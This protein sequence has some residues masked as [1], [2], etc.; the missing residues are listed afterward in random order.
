MITRIFSDHL[1]GAVGALA[2]CGLVL[3]GCAGTKE[4]R[5][6]TDTSDACYQYRVALDATGDF[7]A[8]DIMKGAVVGAIGGAMLG[9]V[10]G[11]DLKSAAIGAAGGALVGAAGGYWMSRQQQTKDKQVLYNSVLT[12]MDAELIKVNEAQFALDQ[13]VNC[14]KKQAR[15]IR[16][17]LKGKRI[18]R[19]QAEAQFVSLRGKLADDYTLAKK[20][21]E[22]VQKRSSDFLYANEQIN[23]GSTNRVKVQAQ[24]AAARTQAGSNGKPGGGAVQKRNLAEGQAANQVD[25]S[26][27]QLATRAQVISNRTNELQTASLSGASVDGS[28]G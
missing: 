3:A 7:F 27:L 22:D 20:V 15:D 23:P 16:Q 12:D 1:R 8:E 2:L 13:L 26:A 5:V 21:N 25:K 11:G 28:F 4:E 24:Q 18:G 19:E 14:R 10:A 6:G 9:L 17:A